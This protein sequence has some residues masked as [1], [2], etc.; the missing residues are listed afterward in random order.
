MFSLKDRSK[1]YIKRKYIVWFYAQNF[2]NFS[3]Y[4]VSQQVLLDWSEPSQHIDLIL[5]TGGTGFSPRDVTPEATKAI[6]DKEANAIITG[7]IVAGLKVTPVAVLS[8]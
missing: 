1:H 4:S 8:R 2:I 6:I 3:N 5:T 7:I